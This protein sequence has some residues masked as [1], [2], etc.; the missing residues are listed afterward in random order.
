MAVGRPIQGPQVFLAVGL[1]RMNLLIDRVYCPK[2]GE[3][4]TRPPQYRVI[5]CRPCHRYLPVTDI[6]LHQLASGQGADLQSLMQDGDVRDS[7]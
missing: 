5:E 7:Y 4:M 3:L 2:C 1:D 6:L